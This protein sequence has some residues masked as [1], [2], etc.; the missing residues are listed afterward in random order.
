VKRTIILLAGVVL[1]VAACGTQKDSTQT[2]ATNTDRQLKQYQAVQPV[3]FYNWSQDRATLIQIYNAKNEARQT[4]TVF[5][6]AAG[7][8]QAMCPSVGYPIPANTQLTSPDQV[9]YVSSYGVGVISQM[10]PNG[11]YSTTGANGTYVLCV[12]PNGKNAAVYSES[13]VTAFP[14][15]VKIENGQVVDLGGDTTVPIDVNKPANVATP[16]PSTAP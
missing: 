15:E 2:D 13:W 11:L 12:R 16:A 3:P 10:E 7:T 8:P 1:L 6:S 9:G 4:W 5:Y 14:Y